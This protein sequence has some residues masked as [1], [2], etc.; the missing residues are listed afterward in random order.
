MRTLRPTLMRV[1]MLTLKDWFA[2]VFRTGF[3]TGFSTRFTTGVVIIALIPT[4]GFAADAL[5]V[6]DNPAVEQR[7][8]EISA[9]LRCL[10]C[11]N[12]SLAASRATL[13][14]DLRREVRDR[15]VRGE[16]DDAIRTYLVERYGDFILYRPPWKASTLLLWLGPIL[17]LATG[18][19][20]L[21]R[22]LRRR[23]TRSIASESI[24]VALN[25]E[26]RKQLAHLLSGE[27]AT[28]NK[29]GSHK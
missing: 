16:S 13:A 25:A 15:I 26:E 8:V 4:P 1:S 12:E 27:K 29:K 24:N 2:N 20:L 22:Q 21:F 19:T 17:L 3:M 23:A 7:L 11:Q 10:V 6:A 14:I 5:P 9:E 18:L 28:D